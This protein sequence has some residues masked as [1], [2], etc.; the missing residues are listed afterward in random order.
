MESP[1]SVIRSVWTAPPPRQPSGNDSLDGFQPRGFDL[2]GGSGYTPW[3]RQSQ[4]AP[5]TRW[6]HAESLGGGFFRRFGAVSVFRTRPVLR[7]RSIARRRAI[8]DAIIGG[9]PAVVDLPA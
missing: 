6:G 5:L 7:F 8:L 1:V 4:L 2:G 9:P 3:S